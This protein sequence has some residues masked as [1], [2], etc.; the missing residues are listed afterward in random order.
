[1]GIE[2]RSLVDDPDHPEIVE[3]GQTFLDNAL[4]KARTISARTGEIVLADDS[5][6]EVEALAGG[7]G[8]HSARYAGEGADDDANIG[9]LLSALAGLSPEQRKAAFRCVLV[10]YRPDGTFESFEGRWEGRIAVAPAGEEGFGYD[11]I[12]FLPEKGVTVAELPSAVK[13]GISH[14]ALAFAKLKA[15]LAA[16]LENNGA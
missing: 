4:K 3:D 8:I 6:L 11:P 15:H 9:K 16:T 5:G 7:P 10:L 14:R 2:L 1:M 13:N 12:F